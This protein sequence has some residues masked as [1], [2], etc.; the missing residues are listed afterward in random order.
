M[1]TQQVNPNVWIDENG[2][3]HYLHDGIWIGPSAVNGDT[4]YFSVQSAANDANGDPVYFEITD[5]KMI[6]TENGQYLY[7]P[8]LDDNIWYGQDKIFKLNNDRSNWEQKKRGENYPES[9]SREDESTVI[10]LTDIKIVSILSKYY[11]TIEELSKYYKDCIKFIELIVKIHGNINLSLLKVRSR[12][13]YNYIFNNYMY[14][15][16]KVPNISLAKKYKNLK[17]NHIK[18]TIFRTLMEDENIAIFKT[19]F[20]H[21][22]EV[23][24]QDMLYYR[25]ILFYLRYHTQEQIDEQVTEYIRNFKKSEYRELITEEYEKIEDY[26]KDALEA[27]ISTPLNVLEID[28]SGLL[29]TVPEMRRG[30]DTVSAFEDDFVV[31]CLTNAKCY[32]YI[33]SNNN[34]F[35]VKLTNENSTAM[36]YKEDILINGILSFRKWLFKCIG[37]PMKNPDGSTSTDGVM[38]ELIYAD[39]DGNKLIEPITY[40]PLPIKGGSVSLVSL[41]NIFSILHSKNRVVYVVM[42]EPIIR[43]VSWNVLYNYNPTARVSA[44]HCQDGSNQQVYELHLSNGE[45]SKKAQSIRKQYDEAAEPVNKRI[46]SSQDV[47]LDNYRQL[48][49]A[50]RAYHTLEERERIQE[51]LEND[52]IMIELLKQTE[53]ERQKRERERLEKRERRERRE[54]LRL[55]N[56]M[57]EIRKIYRPEQ[58]NFHPDPDGIELVSLPMRNRQ[59]TISNIIQT[60]YSR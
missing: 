55:Q 33:S 13:D 50:D 8:Y 37:D 54:Q 6:N 14:I 28:E 24:L 16:G 10:R 26:L 18:L 43:S 58:L 48:A 46:L 17:L 44:K 7:C 56:A 20:R 31:S 30:S 15:L 51:E 1:Q 40:A 2:F 12:P 9:I 5:G 60:P 27:S 42:K 35:S 22:G 34:N 52:Q 32:I 47:Y 49:I 11:D 53:K 36:L 57:E 4:V 38:N 29:G 39:R 45:V 25:I 19:D 21:N 3:P 41:S 59:R 23:I